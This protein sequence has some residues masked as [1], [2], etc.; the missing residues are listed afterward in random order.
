MKRDG[1]VPGRSSEVGDE[2][3]KSSGISEVA[4]PAIPVTDAG[5]SR[6]IKGKGSIQSNIRPGVHGLIGPDK[7]VLHRILQVTSC[8]IKVA[9]TGISRSIERERCI[10]PDTPGTIDD[11]FLPD[12][13]CP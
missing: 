2:R 3:R 8:L 5:I 1:T 10:L 12:A 4:I 6:A 7:P 13:P 11:F 9:D